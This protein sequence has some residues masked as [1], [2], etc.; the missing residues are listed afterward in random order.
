[1]HNQPFMSRRLK[2]R[3][4]FVLFSVVIFLIFLFLYIY[5]FQWFIPSFSF[6][7][8]AAAAATLSSICFFFFGLRNSGES[9]MLKLGISG[10]AGTFTLFAIF[11][12]SALITNVLGNPH[13]EKGSVIAYYWSSKS[14]GYR[15]LLNELTPIGGGFCKAGQNENHFNGVN[16][17]DI[18]AKE[19]ILG[20]LVLSIEP[21]LANT[22][23]KRD[24][25]K[26]AP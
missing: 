5:L 11:G 21:A 14:C 13:N 6:L 15:L 8:F 20:T 26:R 3:H 10:T 19:T 23:F 4:I 18:K 16:F 7:I 17:V 22:S 25:P 24:A 2:L 1:M 12:L 9:L